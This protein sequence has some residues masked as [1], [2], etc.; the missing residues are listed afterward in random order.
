MKYTAIADRALETLFVVGRPAPTRLELADAYPFTTRG[1]LEEK[2]W[3]VRVLAWRQAHRRGERR[4]VDKPRR[5]TYAPEFD[6]DTPD[7]FGG[8]W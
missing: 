7:F 8:N 2:I 6:T 5:A 1:Y 3:C 4:P